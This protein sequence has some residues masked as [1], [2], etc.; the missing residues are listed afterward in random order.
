MS[1]L[2]IPGTGAVA[3]LIFRRKLFLSREASFC[4]GQLGSICHTILDAHGRAV[5][6]RPPGHAIGTK[7]CT[8]ICIHEFRT[9]RKRAL[10]TGGGFII[11]PIHPKRILR[12]EVVSMVL[13]QR[14]CYHSTQQHKTAC[15]TSG[16]DRV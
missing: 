15:A 14:T 10:R 9:F 3:R 7:E 11:R 2:F 8:P 1:Q 13:I 12:K 16:R 4:G 6:V 5:A